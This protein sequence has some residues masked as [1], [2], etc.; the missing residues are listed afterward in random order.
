MRTYSRTPGIVF[1]VLFFS[2]PLFPQTSGTTFEIGKPIEREL[3]G[4]S[5][6]VYV[7]NSPSGHY[8]NLVVDQKGIDIVL[9]LKDPK[10]SQVIEV[11]SPNGAS[12]PESLLAITESEG[13]YSIEIEALDRNAKPGNYSA[14]I[15]EF[16]PTNE[17]DAH[18]ID[19]RR[20]GAEVVKRFVDPKSDRV[21][22]A[23]ELQGVAAAF[24]R[25][26]NDAARRAE[27]LSRTAIQLRAY[28]RNSEAMLLFEE[29]A[30][31]YL[32]A[33]KKGDA[34]RLI[35]DAA[36]LAPSPEEKEIRQVRAVSIFESI[37]DY[38]L[39]I[40]RILDVGIDAYHKGDFRL[41]LR[42]FKEGLEVAEKYNVKPSLIA[43]LGNL[44]NV[45]AAQN[46][47]ANAL[48]SHNRSMALETASG[49]P[50][51]GPTLLNI[52]NVYHGIGEYDLALKNYEEALKIF[53]NGRSPG[54]MAFAV[55]NIGAVYL[56]QG[57]YEKAL[58][59]L[60][61]A[62][63]M[64][65][66]IMPNDTESLS[67]IGAVFRQQGRLNEASEYAQRELDLCKR[68]ENKECETTALLALSKISLSSNNAAAALEMITNAVE[69]SRKN[70]YIPH[71]A[72]AL[73]LEGKAYS[74]QLKDKEAE[75]SLVESIS[76]I[77]RLSNN[78]I[79][80][81]ETEASFAEVKTRPYELL[82]ELLVRGTRYADALVVAERMKARMLVDTISKGRV[83]VARSLSE[84]EQAAERTLRNDLVRLAAK[85]PAEKDTEKRAALREHLNKKRLELEEFRIGL[86]S[87]HPELRT[88]R[89]E[90]PTIN[91]DET[92]KL[93]SHSHSALVEFVV[94]ENR[95]FLFA[96]T[97]G[98]QNKPFL[99]VQAVEVPAKR[100]EHLVNDH[101]SRISAGSLDFTASSKEL[102]SLLLHPLK[103]QL[104]GKANVVIV[105]HGPLWNLPFQTLM[106][107]DGKYLIEN[108]A[109]S[110]APSLTALR[111]MTRR[112]KQRAPAADAELIAFG[113]PIVEK[114][115]KVRVRRVF[116]NETMEPLPEAEKLVNELGRMYGPK[117]SK[118]FTGADAREEVAK[119][120][121]PKYRIVQFA[122]HG[123][124][125]NVSPM[126][127]HLVFAQNDKNPSE[128]GLL[129]AWELKD[130]DLKA[131][132]V[133][134]TA[135]ETARGKISN[136]EGMIGMTWASFIAGAPTT[137][138]SQWK[139][140]SSSTTE[141]ML[142]FHRQLLSKKKVSK[143]EAL[144]RASLKVMKMPKYRHPSYWAGF[145]IV[146]DAS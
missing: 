48:A 74:A 98:S 71:L 78:F 79:G 22:A 56:E 130:L 135:C 46:D 83:E 109:V 80:D 23:A 129:E 112:A 86:Y 76:I 24:R 17:G 28:R 117:R 142:E 62:Q 131:D 146:G 116:M 66:K 25:I 42:K 59:Y 67:N 45:Y 34:A 11:D 92:A 9:R 20:K 63:Q 40:A 47:F 30:E 141:L 37:G 93:L 26:S 99:T 70:D 52:G 43:A 10:G 6:D 49:N 27:G 81:E 75:T 8:V 139:V 16:R 114:E 72:E 102:Y 97:N 113:N 108:A 128:D 126:Y 104:D 84:S 3:R 31:N 89:G 57:Q 58:E 101:L 19:G 15:V 95:T 137:V 136:G 13:R 4:G 1:A 36:N 18:Y 69:I 77:E 65:L 21:A 5:K 87:A 120:E 110:Y 14:R 90:T 54:G 133:I 140:E 125:N 122:T 123:V 2:G 96:I 38:R 82:T 115:T 88:Q 118:V 144:R 32:A 119:A 106:D 111:E 124:L 41:A 29:A 12:G 53:E 55:S 143:A 94:T 134:L 91:L 61:R 50:P 138:A 103:A 44:G 107:K 51:S 132:M 68:L 64:K 73:F 35:N 33:G 121:S 100:L 105:P 60:L 7:L 127:S 39:T 85:I 145:V